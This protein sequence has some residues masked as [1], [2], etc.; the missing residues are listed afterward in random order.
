[1]TE[2][3]RQIG[4]DRPDHRAENC[5]QSTGCK[6][7]Y[8]DMLLFEGRDL[9]SMLTRGP[10]NPRRA[11][12]IVG[13][14]AKALHAAHK[15]GSVHRD[16]K[17]SNILLDED[18]FAYLIDFC[19]ARAINESGLT[20]TGT[21]N[22]TWHHMAPERLSGREADPRSDIYALACVLYEALT[23]RGGG[24]VSCATRDGEKPD[25]RYATTVE[26]AQA[27]YEATSP[28]APAAPSEHAPTHDAQWFTPTLADAV[29]R[30]TMFVPRFMTSTRL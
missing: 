17:P 26:L 25:Q 6:P 2:H 3:D 23:G 18:D 20:S 1:M 29:L 11:V 24:A 5:C 4:G 7:L 10:L 9:E 19:I 14:L 16:V 28:P 22:G 21:V 30:R 15:V 13:Q 27:A 12:A 8:V